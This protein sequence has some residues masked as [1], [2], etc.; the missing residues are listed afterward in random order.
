MTLAFYRGYSLVV[1]ALLQIL[2]RDV[3]DNSCIPTID[4][5]K[6][7]LD[8]SKTQNQ[9]ANTPDPTCEMDSADIQTYFDTGGQIDFALE[10]LVDR[11]Y[12]R[13]PEGPEYGRKPMFQEEERDFEKEIQELP[14]CVHDLDFTLVRVRLGLSPQS[15]GPHWFFLTDDE[16]SE[17][18]EEDE[19][20]YEG[21][22]A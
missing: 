8:L 10:A 12:E 17:G 2:L 7:R 20:I 3:D 19:V 11:A 4:A 5:I 21:Q 13:S 15:N 6:A 1:E 16:D 14:H 22:Q 18:D 9:D